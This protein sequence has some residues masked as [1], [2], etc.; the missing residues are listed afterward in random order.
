MVELLPHTQMTRKGTEVP[1]LAP[2]GMKLKLQS[3]TDLSHSQ[4]LLQVQKEQTAAGS[5][6]MVKMF[7]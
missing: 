6:H 7:T 4:G 3:L 2:Q 1:K 5:F